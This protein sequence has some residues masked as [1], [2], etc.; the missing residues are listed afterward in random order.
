MNIEDVISRCRGVGYVPT[1]TVEILTR[2]SAEFVW[3]D[4]FVH[5]IDSPVILAPRSSPP[6]S[7]LIIA[8]TTILP[9]PL[10]PSSTDSTLAKTPS[11][12]DSTREQNIL[13]EKT[14]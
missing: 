7:A 8:Q 6:L 2:V 11:P 4:S 3:A 14:T 5:P 10:P 13:V 9:I 1:H 12:I